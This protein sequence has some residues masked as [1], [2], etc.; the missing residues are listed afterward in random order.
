MS[1]RTEPSTGALDSVLPRRIQ[2]R[3]DRSSRVHALATK[4]EGVPLEVADLQH[5]RYVPFQALQ[6]AID[7]FDEPTMFFRIRIGGPRIAQEVEGHPESGQRRPQ[8]VGERGEELRPGQLIGSAAI[9]LCALHAFSFPRFHRPGRRTGTSQPL[10][11]TLLH[12]S[13]RNAS[14][15]ISAAFS[16]VLPGAC[17]GLQRYLRARAPSHA[18]ARLEPAHMRLT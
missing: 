10:L 12:V 17:T 18:P 5:V 4:G 14:G 2:R 9:V 15:S 11:R 13:G 7:G 1:S 8:F 16:H 6:A 3:R